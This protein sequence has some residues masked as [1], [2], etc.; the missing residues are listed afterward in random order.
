MRGLSRAGEHIVA[1]AVALPVLLSAVLVCS[2]TDQAAPAQQDHDA[3]SLRLSVD[4]ALVVLRATVTDR[5][6]GSVHSLGEQ[7][8]EVYE[9]GVR[10]RIRL[11]KNED[12]HF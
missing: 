4:V 11:F 12:T 8:F 6:G 7:D 10:Q 5:K 9:D 1:K 3:D 2:G